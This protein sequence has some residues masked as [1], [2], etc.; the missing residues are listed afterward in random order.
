MC[1]ELFAGLDAPWSQEMRRKGFSVVAFEVRHG[2]RYDLTR[3]DTQEFILAM[4]RGGRVEVV[5]MGTP[6]HAG[7]SLDEVW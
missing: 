6:A 3:C 4:I 7:P 2:A 1:L 5:H